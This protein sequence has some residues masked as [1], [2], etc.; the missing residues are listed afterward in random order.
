[1]KSATEL[2]F[3]PA[4]LLMMAF[5][6]ATLGLKIYVITKL[7]FKGQHLPNY[8]RVERLISFYIKKRMLA[9]R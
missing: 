4:I 1:M 6:I 9:F 3:H 7:V 2:I 8:Q 5:T